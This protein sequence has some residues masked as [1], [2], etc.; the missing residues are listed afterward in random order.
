LVDWSI[1]FLSCSVP[2]IQHDF[3]ILIWTQIFFSL[4]AI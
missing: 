2:N 4:M 3:Y 1:P